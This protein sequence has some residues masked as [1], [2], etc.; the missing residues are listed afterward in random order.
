MSRPLHTIIAKFL[1]RGVIV[2]RGSDEA[3]SEPLKEKKMEGDRKTG[4]QPDGITEGAGEVWFLVFSAT[5]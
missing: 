3:V 4:K 2:Q 1:L 5:G